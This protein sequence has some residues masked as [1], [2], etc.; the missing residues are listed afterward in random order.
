SVAAKQGAPRLGQSSGA[1]VDRQALKF[2]RAASGQ[3][4]G[5]QIEVDVVG[6][7]QVQVAVAVIIEK[8]AA[9]APLGVLGTQAS[10]RGYVGGRPVAI[11]VVER[12]AAPVGDEEIIETVVIVIADAHG[13]APSGSRQAGLVGNI[14]KRS[15][16]VVAQQPVRWLPS[17]SRF[18]RSSVDQENV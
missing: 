9:C 1:A 6:D 5:L 8:G 17:L 15:V 13:L 11:V 2:A 7:K 3:G 18:E 14:A 10:L 12:V 16:A 4:S